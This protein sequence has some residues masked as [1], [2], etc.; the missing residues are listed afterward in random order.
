MLRGLRANLT[1]VLLC[2]LTVQGCSD[3]KN[4]VPSTTPKTVETGKMTIDTSDWGT[5]PSG[6]TVEA[7]TLSNAQGVKVVILELG[8]IM[9]ALDVPD[10]DGNTV[11]IL[12]SCDSV[13]SYL[14]DSPHFGATTG[15]YANRI[16]KGTFSL[17]DTEY[18]LALNNGPNHLHG[19]DIGFN[20]VLWKGEPFKTAD[21]VGV[22][23]IYLSKGMEEGYPGNLNNTLTYTLNN[24][25]ELKLYFE[26]TTDKATIVNLTNHSYYNL[27]GHNAGSILD[28]ELTILASHYTPT[29]ENFIPTGEFEVVLGTPLAFTIPK[30]IGHNI[31]EIQGDPGGYDH[32]FVLD[33][34]G[35]SLSLAARVKDPKS[36][37]IM[38]VWND[39]VGIQFYTGNFLAGDFIAKDGANYSKQS[40]FCLESQKFPDSPN[41]PNFPSAVLRPSETYEHTIVMKFSAE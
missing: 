21:E 1:I 3:S 24:D 20:K 7:F 22:K 35:E 32:N 16:A 17:D 28:H 15:R 19:G 12:L 40:G 36:G 26:S 33:H 13:E 11:D 6:K 10:K 25:N 38:E 37:R 34:Q 5:M 27:S 8:G 23:L 4:P 9:H 30:A 29:D 41:Q 2:G 31:A 18:T 39:E 14:N